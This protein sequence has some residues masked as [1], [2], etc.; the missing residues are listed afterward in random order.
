MEAKW[1]NMAEVI[2]E[3]REPLH[4]V[5]RKGAEMI[6]KEARR[7]APVGKDTWVSAGRSGGAMANSHLK[8]K[9]D[10]RKSKFKD[11][12]YIITA[13]G[14]GNY[15]K[16]YASFVELG[17]YKMAAQP[18]MR[19]SIKRNRPRIQRMWQEALNK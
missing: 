2:K 12:G 8:D 16:F 14:S 15:D 1:R 6:A 18:F 10:V 13:H 17:T 11:G 5:T 7:N 9:I 4:A 19:P 3:I